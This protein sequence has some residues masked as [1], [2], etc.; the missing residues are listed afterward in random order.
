MEKTRHIDAFFEKH[1]QGE[2]YT[3]SAHLLQNFIEYSNIKKSP[4]KKREIYNWIV[5]NNEEIVEF[6]K[7]KEETG[8]S[9]YL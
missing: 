1:K 9:Y 2:K 6:Y 3:R 8:H 4:F 7:K 5:R